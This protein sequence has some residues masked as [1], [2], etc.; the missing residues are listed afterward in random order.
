MLTRSPPMR[1]VAF[2]IAFFVVAFGLLLFV[3]Q[4]FGGVTPLQAHGYRVHV[5]FAQAQNLQPN[6]DVRMAG[7]RIGKVVSVTPTTKRTDAALEIDARYAPLRSGT[8]VITRIKTLLGETF[9]ALAPGSPAAP[10][11]PEGATIADANVAPTQQLDEVLGAFDAKTRA[12]LRRFLELT[13]AAVADRGDELNQSL[14]HLGPAAEDLDTLISTLDDQGPQL[15]AFV[16]RTADVFTALAGRPE[17]LRRLVRAGD[18]LL[19]TTDDARDGLRQTVDALG[20]LARELT[21]STIS[22][23]AAARAAAPT[24]RTLR[25]ASGHAP[26]ALSGAQ[27]LAHELTLLLRRLPPSMRATRAGL[28]AAV[29][30]VQATRP[31]DAQ[32]LDAGRQAVPVLDL[33]RAYAQDLVG[34]LAAFAALQQPTARGSDGVARHY[35]RALIIVNNE[36]SAKQ[37]ARPASNRHNAYPRPGWLNDLAAGKLTSSDCDNAKP[38]GANTTPPLSLDPPAPCLVQPGWPF[39][40]ST[41]YY[42]AV[43][44]AP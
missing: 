10:P 27:R 8:R 22:A 21:A 39:R 25:P 15:R 17:S 28:P 16:G 32:L 11:I 31:L 34:S 24:M 20:P 42:P 23:L 14:G 26:A 12:R 6:A 1:S 3:W 41:R 38:G 40:G 4:R 30:L 44:E 37:T 7:V 2:T 36:V 29:R 33:A 43:T 13:A 19:A 18:T 9:V 5:R 35:L